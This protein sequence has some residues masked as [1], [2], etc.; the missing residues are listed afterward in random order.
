[1]LAAC[2]VACGWNEAIP[3][4]E[5][6]NNNTTTKMEGATPSK[7]IQTDGNKIPTVKKWT[8]LKRSDIHPNANWLKELNTVE[9]AIK[10]PAIVL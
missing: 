5:T 10:R 7:L 9:M 6:D 8:D 1:M 4:P 3:I 2:A